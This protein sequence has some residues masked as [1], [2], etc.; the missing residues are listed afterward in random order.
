MPPATLGSPNNVIS[1]TAKA[2]VTYS[3]LVSS[4]LNPTTWNKLTDIPAGA[5]RPITV[6]DP[7]T[8]NRR[9]YKLTTP[10]VP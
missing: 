1:F 5:E 4:D 10:Q 9:F 2:N 3:I 8:P 6:N 7:A